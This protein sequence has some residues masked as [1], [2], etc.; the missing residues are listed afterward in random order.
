MG[1]GNETREGSIRNAWNAVDNAFDF[2]AVHRGFTPYNQ[3]QGKIHVY[4]ENKRRKRKTTVYRTTDDVYAYAVCE[5]RAWYQYACMYVCV[6][7]S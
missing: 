4:S 6:Q 3:S 7:S 2:D 5:Q 1:G